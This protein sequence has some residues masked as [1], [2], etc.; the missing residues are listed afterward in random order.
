MQVYQPHLISAILNE[1]WAIDEKAVHDL[2]V[3]I[4][5][6]LNQGVV[7]EKGEPVTPSTQSVLLIRIKVGQLQEMPEHQQPDIIMEFIKR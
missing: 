6:I 3:T 5:N 7:F 2:S 1:P 4:G